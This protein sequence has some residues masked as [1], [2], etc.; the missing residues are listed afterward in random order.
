M[1]EDARNITP[2]KG[3]R[4][5]HAPRARMTPEARQRLDAILAR[6]GES[7]AD[8]LERMIEWEMYE[9]DDDASDERGEG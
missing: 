8:W 9:E 4:T 3:G 6:T 1:G 2:H 7:M 5:A